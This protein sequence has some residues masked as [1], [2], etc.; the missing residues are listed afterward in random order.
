MFY[1]IIMFIVC[2]VKVCFKKLLVNGL[3]NHKFSPGKIKE[4]MIKL[5]ITPLHLSCFIRNIFLL[6]A[7]LGYASKILHSAA[8]AAMYPLKNHR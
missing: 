4:I 3:F 1:F 2:V 6:D 7:T 8:V 5:T